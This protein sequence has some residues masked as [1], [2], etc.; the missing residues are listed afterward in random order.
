MVMKIVYMGMEFGII[1]CSVPVQR[2]LRGMPALLW[3]ASVCALTILFMLDTWL[4]PN[5][6]T[7]N[8]DVLAQ[9]SQRMRPRDAAA[10]G[11]ER[12]EKRTPKNITLDERRLP[13]RRRWMQL[14]QP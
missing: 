12:R 13:E 1:L 11:S 10:H 7:Q 5:P 4:N 14:L 9:V 2:T 8:T 6:M 3:R